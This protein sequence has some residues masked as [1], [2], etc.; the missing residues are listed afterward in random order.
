MTLNP[1]KA[2]NRYLTKKIHLIA[3]DAIR[4]LEVTKLITSNFI[5]SNVVI[6][7]MIENMAKK[8]IKDAMDDQRARLIQVTKDLCAVSLQIGN[9]RAKV[10]DIEKIISYISKEFAILEKDLEAFK[11]EISKIK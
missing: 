1:I 11:E 2:I 4:N 3:Y 7:T 8:V 10:N 5:G 6:S 9:E